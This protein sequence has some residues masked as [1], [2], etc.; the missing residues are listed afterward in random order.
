MKSAF[1]TQSATALAITV[2]LVCAAGCEKPPAART[3]PAANE[4]E[5]LPAKPVPVAGANNSGPDKDVDSAETPAAGRSDETADVKVIAYYFHR[6]MR[7][8]TC[9]SIEKQAREAI[10]IAYSEELRSGKLE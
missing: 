7:C 1:V 2:C 8:P 5:S 3:A 9:L 10:E 6:T 4:R